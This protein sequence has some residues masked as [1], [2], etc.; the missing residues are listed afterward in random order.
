MQ[1]NNIQRIY[2]M[3]R[4]L[5]GLHHSLM[6]AVSIYAFSWPGVVVAQSNTDLAKASQNPLASMI[7]LPFQNNTN[8]DY[9]PDEKTQNTLNIQPV[10]PV[11]LNENWNV[12][13]RTIIPVVSNPALTP[14]DNRTDGLGDTSFTGWISPA[15]ASKLLWGVGPSVT[16][17]TSTDDK[18][19]A[20][21]WALGP[22]VVI[23]SMPGNWVV[24]SLFSNVWGVSGNEDIDFFTW[25]PIVNYNLSDGWY[26]AFVPIITADWEADSDQ[27]WTVPIGGGVGKIFRMGKQPINMSTHLYHNIEKP[28]AVG[29]WTLRVQ[30][31]LMFPK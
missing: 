30:F 6:A 7:S 10:W 2:I 17:P 21:E 31:Q 15:A 26:L 20:G 23:L 12:V 8:F 3:K 24:G 27:R 29:D 5:I 18:L 14:D 11:K 22:S 4:I 28:D 9:G 25:Q 19:G 1:I 16:I 13:T